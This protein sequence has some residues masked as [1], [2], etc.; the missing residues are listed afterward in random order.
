MCLITADLTYPN[1]QF[2]KFFLKLTD[3]SERRLL[4]GAAGVEKDFEYNHDHILSK[5]IFRICN[6]AHSP[7]C[8]ERER[9]VPVTLVRMRP[10]DRR[11]RND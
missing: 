3:Q 8:A 1:P 10:S 7:Q 2:W 9:P 11:S 4:G 6:S 5:A